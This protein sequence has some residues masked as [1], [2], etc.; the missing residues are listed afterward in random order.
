MRNL[1]SFVNDILIKARFVD[2]NQ[3]ENSFKL[4]IYKA[5]KS[6]EKQVHSS[7]DN[8]IQKSLSIQKGIEDLTPEEIQA[9]ASFELGE[10]PKQ[11][12]SL[13]A[14]SSQKGLERAYSDLKM[15]LSWNIDMTPVADF[16]DEHYKDFSKLLAGDI[17]ERTKEIIKDSI[18][19]G[20]PIEDIHQQI[21]KLFDGP[22]RIRVP[23]KVNDMGEVVRKEYSYVMDKDR[24]T[25]MVARTEMNRALNNGRVYGYQQSDIAK[26]LRWVT[27]PGA[28]ELCTPMNGQIYSVEES[29]DVLPYHPNCRCTWIVSEYKKY[30]EPTEATDMFAD[31]DTIF[32]A[33]DGV[34]I[35]S[36]FQLSRAEEDKLYK[37]I[38]EGSTEEAM[39]ILRQKEK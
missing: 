8:I 36:F 25:T 37:L 29:M 18:K 3:E 17:Q 9:I 21:S 22:L 4:Y 12:A 34:H 19:Q 20:T 7:L 31:P 33:K 32:S 27:N 11:L 13:A 14:A 30:E 10:L 16:Y 15:L 6:W 38:D 23:A 35:M 2:I 26:S 24:Y 5:I 1:P 28:C 39:K